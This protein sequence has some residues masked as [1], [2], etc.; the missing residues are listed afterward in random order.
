MEAGIA[1]IASLIDIDPEQYRSIAKSSA[2]IFENN[3]N[4]RRSKAE[5]AVLISGSPWVSR[6]CRAVVG[7][8][9]RLRHGGE[10]ADGF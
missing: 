6:N 10:S 9:H 2:T 4:D 7:R 1:V 3:G 8:L 5:A